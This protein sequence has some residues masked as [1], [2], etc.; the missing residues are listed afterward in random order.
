MKADL[1]A[2]ELRFVLGSVSTA[3]CMLPA[4]VVGVPVDAKDLARLV[5]EQAWRAAVRP[6][7]DDGRAVRSVRSMLARLRSGATP[8][9]ED[10]RMVLGRVGITTWWDYAEEAAFLEAELLERMED[11]RKR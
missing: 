2:S 7:A 6:D 8:H 5:S 9:A 3:E 11:G 4:D 10:A 1:V